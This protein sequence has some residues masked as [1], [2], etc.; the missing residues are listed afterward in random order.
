MNGAG[1]DERDVDAVGAKLET[2]RVADQGECRLGS[3]ESAAEWQRQ[4][5]ADRADVDDTPVRLAHEREERL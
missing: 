2:E 5:A 4:V 1:L 3:A